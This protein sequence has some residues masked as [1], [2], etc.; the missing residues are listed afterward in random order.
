LNQEGARLIAE[1]THTRQ[2][3]STEEEKG[4]RLLRELENLRAVATRLDVLT[5]QMVDREAQAQ[6]LR[7]Q[8]ASA[9]E[10]RDNLADQVRGLEQALA[11]ANARAD[12]QR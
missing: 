10:K 11:Q 7:Q 6:D 8:L 9:T 2:A 4:K 5:A 12:A 3:L 1:L